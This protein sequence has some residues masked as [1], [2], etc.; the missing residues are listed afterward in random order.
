LIL[1]ACRWSAG[2]GL[3]GFV[4]NIRFKQTPNPVRVDGRR[5]RPHGRAEPD[6]QG[7][8]ALILTGAAA[9]KAFLPL[10]AIARRSGCLWA[11]G[12]RLPA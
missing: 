2:V 12:G 3:A 8:T 9:F 1:F 5:D 10:S 4:R 11:A 7:V 6:A